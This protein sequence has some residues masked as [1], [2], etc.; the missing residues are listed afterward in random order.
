MPTIRATLS[1]LTVAQRGSPLVN[2][3]LSVRCRAINY[4]LSIRTPN[5]P[6]LR[7]TSAP[8]CSPKGGRLQARG[9]LTT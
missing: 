6:E 1:P 7:L 5:E 3:I 8:I 2:S 9:I 4:P